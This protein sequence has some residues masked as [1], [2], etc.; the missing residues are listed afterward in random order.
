MAHVETA[1]NPNTCPKCG[2][3]RE[4]VVDHKRRE[5]YWVC[6]HC[7]RIENE[8]RE[9]FTQECTTLALQHILTLKPNF[10]QLT[11][12]EQMVWLRE[13]GGWTKLI[14]DATASIVVGPKVLWFSALDVRNRLVSAL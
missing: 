1:S 5:N 11:D 4:W 2:G 12:A 14:T 6:K 8:A 7:I 13:M 3:K 9:Q 10:K